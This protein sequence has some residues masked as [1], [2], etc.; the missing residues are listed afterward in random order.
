MLT[1]AMRWKCYCFISTRPICVLRKPSRSLQSSSSLNTTNSTEYILCVL[2]FL[3]FLQ[4]IPNGFIKDLFHIVRTPLYGFI[5]LA[6]LAGSV[7]MVA[8]VSI[9]KIISCLSRSVRHLASFLCL[10]LEFT[11]FTQWAY[12]S[13][14]SSDDVSR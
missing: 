3:T 4:H 14:S 6:N 13:S 10:F 7:L 9:W 12:S 2:G 5:S 11:A 1:A 8:P